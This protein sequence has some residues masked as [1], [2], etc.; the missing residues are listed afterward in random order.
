MTRS[1]AADSSIKLAFSS[2]CA[3]A[4]LHLHPP[5][6]LVWSKAAVLPPETWAV[7][8]RS[9]AQSSVNGD[10][11][12]ACLWPQHRG[13]WQVGAVT[14][15]AAGDLLQCWLAV[16]SMISGGVP[17]T[18]Y[19]FGRWRRAKGR[20]GWTR[21]ESWHLRNCPGERGKPDGGRERGERPVKYW[22]VPAA[23]CVGC[24]HEVP[25]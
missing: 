9:Q 20:V 3:T 8:C 18:R 25:G 21:G 22:Q 12:R 23:V 15:E 6:S 14:L 19:S 2:F 4:R 5:C 11:G 16:D 13:D 24:A 10:Q 7:M 1:S 17:P